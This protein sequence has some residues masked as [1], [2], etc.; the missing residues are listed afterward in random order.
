MVG[1]SDFLDTP[2][3]HFGHCRNSLKRPLGQPRPTFWAPWKHLGDPAA[4]GTLIRSDFDFAGNSEDINW[5][6]IGMK[7]PAEYQKYVRNTV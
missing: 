3:Q 5:K 6:P 2:D 1:Q 7:G 4:S